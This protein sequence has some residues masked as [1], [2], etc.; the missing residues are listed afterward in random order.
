LNEFFV[1]KNIDLNVNIQNIDFD[2]ILILKYDFLICLIKLKY[3]IPENE[4]NDFLILFF[5]FFYF[6]FDDFYLLFIFILLQF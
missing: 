3:L 6:L 2:K 1:N 4:K 5:N